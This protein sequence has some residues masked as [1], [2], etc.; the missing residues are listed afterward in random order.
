MPSAKQD[1]VSTEELLL[2]VFAGLYIAV[3]HLDVSTFTRALHIVGGCPF[4]NN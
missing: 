2:L 3:E 1:T 4:V